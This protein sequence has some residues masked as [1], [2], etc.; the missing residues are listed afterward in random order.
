METYY[1]PEDLH[2]F[3]TISFCGVRLAN[4]PAWEVYLQTHS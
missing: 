2:N 4:L 3:S 1:N